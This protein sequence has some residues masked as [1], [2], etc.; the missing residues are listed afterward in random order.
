V[1]LLPSCVSEEGS[2]VCCGRS[3]LKRNERLCHSRI[4]ITA[5]KDVC[6]ARNPEMRTLSEMWRLF[7]LPAVSFFVTV[8]NLQQSEPRSDRFMCLFYCNLKF[9]AI[10]QFFVLESRAMRVCLCRGV[11][12]HCLVI[13]KVCN[14]WARWGPLEV[15]KPLSYN[16][17]QRRNV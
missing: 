9:C 15:N 13:C 8:A 11:S 5:I 14:I 12:A 3:K 4:N 1:L 16:S 17:V 2:R 10:D 7:M 6:R